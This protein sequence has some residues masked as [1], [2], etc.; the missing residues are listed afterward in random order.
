MLI[1]LCTTWNLCH[2]PAGNLA[3]HV[4]RWRWR[5]VSAS[6]LGFSLSV[7]FS[8]AANGR[9]LKR[10]K[11]IMKTQYVYEAE[12]ESTYKA[13]LLKGLQRTAEE[14]RFNCVIGTLLV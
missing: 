2:T 4:Y 9:V 13:S 8:P 5:T 11:K 1:H 10:R 3:I 12:M 14:R 6:V 7:C